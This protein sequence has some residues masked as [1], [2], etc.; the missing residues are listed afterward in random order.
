MPDLGLRPPVTQGGVYPVLHSGITPPYL[1]TLEKA[2]KWTPTPHPWYV[3]HQSMALWHSHFRGTS[4][5]WLL[6][7]PLLCTLTLWL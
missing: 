5:P 3:V 4:P 2:R 7:P 6:A 1:G